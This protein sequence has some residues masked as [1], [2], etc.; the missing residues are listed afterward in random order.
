[1]GLPPNPPTENLLNS[2]SPSFGELGPLAPALVTRPRGAPVVGMAGAGPVMLALRPRG[3]P[4]ARGPTPGGG[5]EDDPVVFV[6]WGHPQRAPPEKRAA[7]RGDS[8]EVGGSAL[9][10][11]GARS[12]IPS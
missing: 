2:P 11:T 12:S 7:T 10:E 3:A 9:G 1:M 4:P 8:G 6:D 5:G